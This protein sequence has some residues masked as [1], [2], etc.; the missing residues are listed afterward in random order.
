MLG[1]EEGYEA[2]IVGGTAVSDGKFPFVASMQ[3]DRPGT[4]P[5]QDHFC[6]AIL[7]DPCRVMTAA[8]CA[9]VM[10]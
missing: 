1:A 8:H 9:R 10:S 4:A 2:R 6:G 3:N 7:T 5:L